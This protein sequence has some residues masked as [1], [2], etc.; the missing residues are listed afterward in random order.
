MI[1]PKLKSESQKWSSPPARFSAPSV[2]LRV[3]PP[4]AGAGIAARARSIAAYRGLMRM[5]SLVPVESSED[6]E[7]MAAEVRCHFRKA[8]REHAAISASDENREAVL[9]KAED[10]ADVATAVHDTVLTALQRKGRRGN[11][12]SEVRRNQRPQSAGC[13]RAQRRCLQRGAGSADHIGNGPRT[14][15]RCRK[16]ELPRGGGSSSVQACM[17][18]HRILLTPRSRQPGLLRREEA[19]HRVYHSR[20][21]TP[22][23]LGTPIPPVHLA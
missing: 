9:R 16:H 11:T 7:Y 15:H 19:F 13:V 2:D 10:A 22:V 3:T 4:M 23:S 12:R 20:E 21:C 1:A 18:R 5:T 14:Q 8:A 6:R 17:R